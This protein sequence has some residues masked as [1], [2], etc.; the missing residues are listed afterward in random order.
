MCVY[1]ASRDMYLLA[2]FGRKSLFCRDILTRLR[3]SSDVYWETMWGNRYRH[4]FVGKRK[5]ANIPT[6]STGQ[7]AFP[8]LLPTSIRDHVLDKKSLGKQNISLTPC[9]ALKD[10][11]TNLPPRYV[12]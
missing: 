5:K 2:T 9:S 6:K 11:E 7:A 12:W 4:G 10:N 3:I 1:E 8:R